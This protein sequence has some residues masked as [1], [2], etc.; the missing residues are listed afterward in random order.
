MLGLN[1]ITLISSRVGSFIKRIVTDGLKMRLPFTSAEPLGENL[2]VNGDFSDGTTGWVGQNAT[3]TVVGG[4]LEV[5]STV[6]YGKSVQNITTVVGKRYVL[7][8]K[9]TAGTTIARFEIY[10]SPSAGNIG[11]TVS[12]GTEQISLSFVAAATTTQVQLKCQSSTLGTTYFDNVSV[13]EYAQETPDISGNDNNAIL[14]TGKALVFDGAN[15]GIDISNFSMSGSEGTFAFWYKPQAATDLAYIIDLAESGDG[16][17]V[18]GNRSDRFRV[19]T[20][21]GG[22]G[23]NWTSSDDY[24]VS[25]NEWQRVVVTIDSSKN[26]KIYKN[27]VQLGSTQTSVTNLNIDNVSAAYIG[28]GHGGSG[29]NVID[30]SLSDFQIYNKVWSESD[31]T[32]DYKNPQNLVTDNLSTDVNLR[33]LKAWWHLSEGSGSVIH[34]S[35]PL[36]GA[37]EVVN[38]DFATDS[39]WSKTNATILNGIANIST[40]GDLAGI[41]QSS[42]TTSGKSYKFSFEITSIETLGQ[43][44]SLVSG[45]LTSAILHTF[46]SIGKHTIYFTATSTTIAIKRRSGATD[47]SI[48][49]ISVKEVFNI[50]GD[51]Y[52]DDTNVDGTLLG[53]DWEHSQERIPQLGMMNWSKGSNVLTYSN[54]FQA[55][56]WTSAY[57]ILDEGYEAPDGTMTAW[58]I[59]RD[60]ALGF[61]AV[62]DLTVTPNIGVVRS[63]YAKTVSGT[64]NVHLMNYNTNSNSLITV[65]NEWQRFSI[66]SASANAGIFYAVDFRGS[67]TL[68]EVILWGAQE[69]VNVGDSLSAFRKTDGLPVTNSTLIKTP[70]VEQFTGNK[71]T[72]NLILYSEDFN[73]SYWDGRQNLTIESGYTDPNGG[74]SAYKV[75]ANETYAN[76]LH[77]FNSGIQNYSRSIWAKTVSGSG[78]LSLLSRFNSSNSIQTITNEW[79]RFD[80]SSDDGG[81]PNSFYAIDFRG[82]STLTE[83]LIY[84]AQLQEGTLTRYFPTYGAVAQETLPIIGKDILGNDVET[85]GSALNLDGTGYAEVEHNT[86]F[87]F[88]TGD[89]TLSC[90]AQYKFVDTGSGW[91]VII[92]N[93]NMSSSVSSRGGF[94]LGS[95]S[96]NFAIR[97]SDSTFLETIYIG[98]QLVE[99]QWYHIVVSREGNSLTTYIDTADNTS[100]INTINVTKNQVMNIGVDTTSSRHYKGLIDDVQIY[101]RPLTSDEVEQNY[102]ATKSGHNN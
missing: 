83:V 96:T 89:F 55:S 95:D 102:N 78:T 69:E 36:I 9:V 75:T 16:R 48:D 101:D 86:D 6:G 21:T 28:Q 29:A 32:Y 60:G 61:G 82:S 51:S 34:D 53:A 81:D 66:S 26:L 38:G 92:S 35:A 13:E 94:N 4:E 77:D 93:G 49:N 39:D 100:T 62:Y 12:S 42:V 52:D 47:I 58:K 44:L 23:G 40:T 65:T 56:P 70:D 73:N 17:F 43:G 14:K 54:D 11:Q 85:R 87:D 2:V 79:Q 25:L 22:T 10:S 37:E 7:S 98:S 33:N 68:T 15:D 30:G 19:F 99:G 63:I 88:G 67:S 18:I 59:T 41:V 84:G 1:T 5:T 91:N 90:W 57:V 46:T 50:D 97:L 72:R 76:L 74:N 24:V 80:V 64:G 71:V 3:I 45:G 27:G 8:A 31:V 20:Q